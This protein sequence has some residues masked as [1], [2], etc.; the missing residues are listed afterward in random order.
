MLHTFHG[1]PFECSLTGTKARDPIT[2]S[3]LR[4]SPASFGVVFGQMGVVSERFEEPLQQLEQ[5]TLVALEHFL[6][7]NVLQRACISAAC[8][9]TVHISACLC[10]RG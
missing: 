6:N 1:P 5:G 3:M 7:V 8:A 2:A 4:H 9:M 10:A